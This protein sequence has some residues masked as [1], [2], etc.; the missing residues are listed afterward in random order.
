MALPN[1]PVM[2]LSVVNTL[3]R[4]RYHSLD[5]LCDGEETHRAA[6]EQRLARI[7]YQYVPGVN[8]FR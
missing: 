1:D 3:L 8:Q 6:L 2:L 7:G 5:A 4:D